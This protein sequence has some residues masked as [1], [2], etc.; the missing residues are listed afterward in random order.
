MTLL[1]IVQDVLDEIADFERPATIINNNNRT[2]RE[3]LALA[4]RSGRLLADRKGWSALEKRTSF[5]ANGA[6][7]QASTA[8]PS[9]F[10]WY[11]D[12]TMWDDTNNWPLLG[13][14]TPVER[15]RVKN[16]VISQSV[17]GAFWFQGGFIHLWPSTLTSTIA[18]EYA[19]NAWVDTNSDGVGDAVRWAAD[20][21]TSVLDEDLLRLDLAWRWLKSKGYPYEEDFNEA[22]RAIRRAMARDKG[23]PRVTMEGREYPYLIGYNNIPDTGI[24][25]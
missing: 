18:Y 8:I 21:N 23:K 20:N 14:L 25:V 17:R 2:A 7:Q 15:E 5:T 13:P 3:M 12:R 9:D 1:T 4:N 19:S 22:E 6:E 24:G 16:G 11:L 10:K